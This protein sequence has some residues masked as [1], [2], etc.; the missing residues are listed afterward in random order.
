MEKNILIDQMLKDIKELELIVNGV[1]TMN[2]IH[3][4]MQQL[5]TR[6]FKNLEENFSLVL[7]DS[8]PTDKGAP[9]F[10]DV[11][12]EEDSITSTD[13][14]TTTILLDEDIEE[15]EFVDT[16]KK[17]QP[18]SQP[19]VKSSTSPTI[20]PSQN[21]PRTYTQQKSSIQPE[22]TIHK[23]TPK[24]ASVILATP[25]T[26]AVDARLV[27]DLRRAIGINDR[28]R[29]KRE[30]FGGDEQKMMETIDILNQCSSLQEVEEYIDAHF[31]W[32][33]EDSTY[34]YFSEILH[35]RFA[36]I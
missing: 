8:V 4:I 32:Q 13:D 27:T 5:V 36:H 35:K 1:R 7:Q 29:F 30:L 31:D 17:E 25:K 2:T 3:P 16:H 14:T 9:K 19:T 6:K 11:N 22:T 21:E 18:V 24:P 12:D 23:E 20:P 26:S 33:K 15:I 28:F 10:T 34:V